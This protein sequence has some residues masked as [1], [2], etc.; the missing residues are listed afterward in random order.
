MDQTEYDQS[1]VPGGDFELPEDAKPRDVRGNFFQIDPRTWGV[2]CNTQSIAAAASYLVIA[3]GTVGT[4]RKS[5]W[6]AKSIEM[7]TGLHRSRAKK[8]IEDLLNAGF[9]KL[10][11]KST[12]SRPRYE[13]VSFHEFEE[14]DWP[15][16]VANLNSYQAY[17]F[18]RLQQGPQSPTK[19]EQKATYYEL[20]NLRLAEDWDGVFHVASAP[21]KAPQFIWLPNALVTGTDAGE[22]SPVRLLRGLNDMMALRLLVDLYQAQNLSADGGISREVVR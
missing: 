15:R 4:S 6:S 22:Q 19:K 21:T 8:R 18:E 5:S 14:H 7:Y 9:L 10:D 2:I 16:R 13:V 12:K 11:E 3:Q 1:A 20:V 17:M